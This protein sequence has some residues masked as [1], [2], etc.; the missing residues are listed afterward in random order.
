MKK[1]FTLILILVL[2]SL[3]GCTKKNP[4]DLVY[5]NTLNKEHYDPFTA[6]S[7]LAD[8]ASD[9]TIGSITHGLLTA[10]NSD[11]TDRNIVY[12]GGELKINYFI[13]ADGI[14]KN[15]GFL[16]YVDGIPQPYK[17]QMDNKET[18]YDYVHELRLEDGIEKDVILQFTPVTGHK[19]DILNL[20]IMSI[21]NPSFAPDMKKTTSY[22]YAH[23]ILASNYSFVYDHET[24]G[25]NN[26]ELEKNGCL[27]NSSVSD[28]VLTNENREQLENGWSSGNLDLDKKVY[29]K[30]YIDNKDMGRKS[31]YNLSDEAT[32]HV[33]YKMAGHPGIKYKLILYYDHE[34]IC[35]GNNCYY[36]TELKKGYISVFESDID[37][38]KLGDN[39]TFYIVAVPYNGND[40]PNDLVTVEK[41]RS[42]FFFNESKLNDSGTLLMDD[43]A[44]NEES[45][46]G[47]SV[48]SN[49]NAMEINFNN[50]GNIEEVFYAGDENIFL[51]GDRLY[52]YN[53]DKKEVIAETVRPSGLGGMDIWRLKNGYA[54]VGRSGEESKEKADVWGNGI[55]Y[56]MACSF[57]DLELNLIAIYDIVKQMGINVMSESEVTVSSDGLKIACIGQDGL[58]V[59]D[60]NTDIKKRIANTANTEDS[61]IAG[62]TFTNIAY[63][64][65]NKKIVFLSQNLS[66]DSKENQLS[67]SA[68]GLVNSDGT[69]LICFPGKEFA[70]LYAYN[71]NTLM[72]QDIAL[73]GASGEAVVLNNFTQST[74]LYSLSEKSESEN[75][76]GSEQGNYFSTSVREDAKGWHV[77]IYEMETGK[78][79]YEKV[80]EYENTNHYKEPHI[81]IFDQGKKFLLYFKPM[82]DGVKAKLV[83]TEF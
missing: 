74:S 76:W 26:S 36:E 45:S 52:L 16:I 68:Y 67:Y 33:K 54:I 75:I 7:S 53:I 83:M 38:S 42:I 50:L 69:N 57:Y 6:S 82:Q 35:G 29:T 47:T 23:Q 17:I 2:F 71:N 70:K 21:T 77:R 51:L 41:T 8:N 56:N 14:A 4:G 32:V 80:Y 73:E 61:E 25:W 28:V 13:K 31:S 15:S 12:Q 44:K 9:E 27:Y 43:D 79:V 66:S 5:N 81:Y 46:A 63:V 30:L 48:N 34:P 1:I 72:S 3:A 20:T 18:E 39:G 59:Y 55:I 10:E 58:Y 65:N 64:D 24:G 49:I 60:R 40:F 22:G 11:T 78:K 37:M 62:I 19:G